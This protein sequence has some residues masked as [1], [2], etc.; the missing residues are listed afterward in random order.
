MARRII[1]NMDLCAIVQSVVAAFLLYAAVQTGFLL[2]ESPY[3][4]QK[5]LGVIGLIWR[6]KVLLASVVWNEQ[7]L[8]QR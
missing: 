6:L 1:V 7:G 8:A 4:V 2:V 5:A 3:R